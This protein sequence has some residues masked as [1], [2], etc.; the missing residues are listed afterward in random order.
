M[1]SLLAVDSSGVPPAALFT[2][3]GNASR[4]ASQNPSAPSPM[5]ST[6]A[7]IPR[8]SLLPARRG[9]HCAHPGQ[10]LRLKML[11]VR[12]RHL[13]PLEALFRWFPAADRYT[14]G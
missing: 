13:E 6:G 1:A 5:A 10:Q 9:T 14:P 7:V 2:V 4:T 11:W 3:S 8:Q 12:H